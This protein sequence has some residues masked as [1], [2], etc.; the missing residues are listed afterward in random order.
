[1]LLE[2]AE[3]TLWMPSPHA[4]LLGNLGVIII[5]AISSLQLRIRIC[6]RLQNFRDNLRQSV[7]NEFF[8]LETKKNTVIR[9]FWVYNQAPD[10]VEGSQT[11]G[12]KHAGARQ[13][14][15]ERMENIGCGG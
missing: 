7:E 10:D 11:G 13:S 12:D 2:R 14:K 3:S 6:E 4:P 1:M 9:K 5:F 15:L 8:Q